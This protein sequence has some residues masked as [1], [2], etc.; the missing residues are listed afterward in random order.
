MFRLRKRR[1]LC[2]P[3]KKPCDKKTILAYSYDEANRI[4]QERHKGKGIFTYKE[5]W[6]IV[7]ERKK[8]S[9]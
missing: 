9:K 5:F 8:Y 7:Y 4:C 3:P 6:A 1:F 2:C